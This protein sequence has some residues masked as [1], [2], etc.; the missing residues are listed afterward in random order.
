M[1]TDSNNLKGARVAS[2]DTDKRWYRNL[3]RERETRES[4]D[5]TLSIEKSAALSD[6]N[7]D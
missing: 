1:S 4:L 6:L 3:V 2:S 5:E 7:M